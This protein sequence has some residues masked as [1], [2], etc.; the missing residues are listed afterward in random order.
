MSAKELTEKFNHKTSEKKTKS[1]HVTGKV[2][3]KDNKNKSVLR[4]S[5]TNVI[6]SDLPK[7]SD[8]LLQPVT[9]DSNERSN[10]PTEKSSHTVKNRRK[11]GLFPKLPLDINHFTL[12]DDLLE[13]AKIKS[14]VVKLKRLDSQNH[15]LRETIQTGCKAKEVVKSKGKSYTTLQSEL[16]IGAAQ[17]HLKKFS[18]FKEPVQKHSGSRKEDARIVVETTAT[19]GSKHIVSDVSNIN[20]IEGFGLVSSMYTVDKFKSSTPLKSNI[21]K[22]EDFIINLPANNVEKLII[23]NKSQDLNIVSLRNT[24]EKSEND[25]LVSAYINSPVNHIQKSDTH[26][27]SIFSSNGVEKPNTSTLGSTNTNSLPGYSIASPINSLD[28]PKLSVLRAED[29]NNLF[30]TKTG[31][32]VPASTSHQNNSIGLN[33]EQVSNRNEHL[34]KK[35]LS[36]LR[37]I[38]KSDSV[39]SSSDGSEI[40]ASNG[41]KRS[42]SIAFT[43]KSDSEILKKIRLVDESNDSRPVSRTNNS[44]ALLKEFRKTQSL[45]CSVLNEVD[46]NN[47]NMQTN[48]YSVEVVH[49]VSNN[50]LSSVNVDT[51]K[52]AE[53]KSVN[54]PTTTST[55]GSLTETR[56]TN[57]NFERNLDHCSNT[58]SDRN[59]HPASPIEEVPPVNC[60]TSDLKRFRKNEKD[61]ISTEEIQKNLNL[62]AFETGTSIISIVTTTPVSQSNND[63]KSSTEDAVNMASKCAIYT[64]AAVKIDNLTIAGKDY[65]LP[66]NKSTQESNIDSEV[67]NEMLREAQD[68]ISDISYPIT[69]KP[70]EI[71]SESES[72]VESKCASN[73]SPINS[74]GFSTAQ[75]YFQSDNKL[76]TSLT[77]FEKEETIVKT[78]EYL[79]SP[80][81]STRL[82]E[83]GK[84]FNCDRKEQL[85][86]TLTAVAH[87]CAQTG[88]VS[89][90]N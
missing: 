79:T 80:C 71:P 77:M 61:P 68:S 30:T 36:S 47:D 44:M 5:V 49:N 66:L 50:L 56:K 74:K 81:S 1:E 34:Q 14:A 72:Q 67:E 48:K 62:D 69:I 45:T 20:K 16:K 58:S 18:L 70:E 89:N 12:P 59:K 51:E 38:R 26:D 53:L 76:S 21:N 78:E 13:S 6:H 19:G 28:K 9:I 75:S 60:A 10:L 22:H 17:K 40:C 24:A 54:V 4:P 33:I 41:S 43:K 84:Y 64:D 35:E 46:S 88:K 86:D 83:V 39:N 82:Q 87:K 52:R 32:C 73:T 2:S 15:S 3:L 55:V 25:S 42:S 23:D 8:I 7:S 63:G 65:V 27:V 29:V 85:I 37:H 57:V 31:Y 11:D 90:V